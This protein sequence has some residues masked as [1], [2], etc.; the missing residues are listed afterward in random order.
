M[1]SLIR[2][3]HIGEDSSVRVSER[4]LKDAISGTSELPNRVALIPL[5]TDK[6]LA[7]RESV[8]RTTFTPPEYDL[9]EILTIEDTEALFARS[10]EKKSNLMFKEGWSVV[11][12][13]TEVQDF[14]SKR[15]S[16][17]ARAQGKPWDLLLKETGR[18]LSR[19]SNAMWV[20]VRNRSASGGFPR[21]IPKTDGT[22]DVV[23]PVAAYFI[24][25]LE[26]IEIRRNNA[27]RVTAIRQV[28]EDG[29]KRDF[30]IADIV[31][32]FINKKN[33]WAIGTPV[34]TPVIDDIRTLRRIEENIDL[35]VYQNLFPLFQ[36]KVGTPE[37]PAQIYPDGTTEIDVVRAEISYM[38]P[39]GV[40]VTPE[41]HEIAMVGS[42]GRALRAENYL[43]HFKKRVYAGLGMSTVD[44]GEGSTVNKSTASELSASLIDAVKSL[45]QDFETQFNFL[46]LDELL[47]EGKFDVDPLL[48][49]NA[50]V[51]KFNEIDLD[52]KIKLEEHAADV[53]TKHLLMEDEARHMV[54]REK[55]EIDDERRG[56]SYFKLIE[57]PLALIKGS[58]DATSPMAAAA[59]S[60]EQTSMEPQHMAEAQQNK[61]KEI[62]AK[63][64]PK[65]SPARKNSVRFAEREAFNDNLIKESFDSLL[66]DIKFHLSI[67][68]PTSW[69][70][71]IVELWAKKLSDRFT[72]LIATR[73]RDGVQGTGRGRWEKDFT[74]EL[75]SLEKRTSSYI[76]KLS[77]D[78]KSKLSKI[79]GRAS[80]REIMSLIDISM[81]RINGLYVT[82]VNLAYN[83]GRAIGFGLQ[84]IKYVKMQ[85]HDNIACFECDSILNKVIDLQHFTIEELPPH[86]PYCRCVIEPQET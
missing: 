5:Q 82:E 59:V 72:S 78:V 60:N 47:M 19:F 10:V 57:E 35:L 16:Q 33:G 28:M 45:Q 56:L 51:L 7:F 63:P 52:K 30:P 80:N 81:N 84:N 86:H 73:F 44:F 26:T 74:E 61:E 85:R 48:P 50:A 3:I 2:T 71:T 22:F 79:D 55:L 21:K 12:R 54:G 77:A 18:D 39:E 66:Y 36:Y 29:R 6:T 62:K 42:E 17:I 65:P 20:K 14:V 53:F 64:V 4:T 49:E 46:V 83:Y 24:L 32:F 23:E 27:G 43:E 25:P 31:H 75:S 1:T 34:I 11:S 67:N 37:R 40:L 76:L 58:G 15:L 8:S 69:I 38:P 13:I 41:R 68:T 70:E 9:G